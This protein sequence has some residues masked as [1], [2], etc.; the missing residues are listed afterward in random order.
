M[1]ETPRPLPMPSP[2]PLAQ[3]G[4]SLRPA[5]VADPERI[6]SLDVLRGVAVCGILAMNVVSMGMI[7]AAYFN[8]H[9]AV[10]GPERLA[11]LDYIIW[12]AHHLAADMKF[13]TIFSILFGAGVL[14]FTQ[15]LEQRGKRSAG[16]H[17]R[18]MAWLL[19]FGMLHAYLLWFGDILFTYALCGMAVYLLRKLAPRWLI[20]IAIVLLL[21]PVGLNLLF[22]W[23]TT[24]MPSES[25]EQMQAG[26]SQSW[27]PSAEQIADEQAIYQGGWLG[28]MAHR[29]PTAIM[30]QTFLL[31]L[32]TLW[33]ISGCM[34]LG[35]ALLKL[36]YLA[37]KRSTATY[38]I[39][40]AIGLLIGIPLVLLGVRSNNAHD[41]EAVHGMFVAINFNYTASLFIA[42][43]WISL[44]MIV[45][46]ATSLQTLTRPFA[47]V[48]KMAFTNYIAQ[49][50]ICT[51]LF[52]GHG[53]GYYNTFSRAEMLLLVIA[54]WIAQLIISPLWLSYFRFGP[55]EWLWRSLSYWRLQPLRRAA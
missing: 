50:V 44:I 13:M 19:L 52:Y 11:G 12:L 18:R 53:F 34:L 26:M 17:Y 24:L 32:M 22:A 37:A 54:V 27:A 42:L 41:W 46:R 45:C 4:L 55:L 33:R 1:E 28:Q 49:T 9:A 16:L 2:Q 47:A 15:R 8:P 36:G 39:T 5:P 29:L 3:A 25:A 14:V 43:T 6:G 23:L 40:G 51:T 10:P 7:S 48:G 31:F 21:I 20:P 30:L 38:L 35:M